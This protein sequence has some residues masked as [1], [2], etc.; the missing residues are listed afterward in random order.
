VEAKLALPL[1][2]VPQVITSLESI[3]ASLQVSQ[4][5]VGMEVMAVLLILQALQEEAEV[6]AAATLEE[7][8]VLVDGIRT[9]P[10]TELIP[11]FIVVR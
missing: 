10:H 2:P 11:R 7:V 8:V 3:S 9:K 6:V 5:T 1:V 4:E